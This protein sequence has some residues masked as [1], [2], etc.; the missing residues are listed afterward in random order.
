MPSQEDAPKDE[1]PKSKAPKAPKAPKAKASKSTAPRSK[2]SPKAPK[3]AAPQ[4]PLD[5]LAKVC[6]NVRPAD[7]AE[8]VL[9]VAPRFVAEPS[10][11]AEAAEVMRVAAEHGLAVV[12]R[13]GE[14]RLEWGMPPSRCDLLVDT[15]RLD[16]VIEHA[17]G[18]LVVKAEAGLSMERLAEVLA[19]RGQRL[20]LDTPLP[21]ST[22]GGTIAT[23]A[24]GPLRLLYGSPRDL[25]IGLTFIRADGQIARSG[26]K[27]VKNV[28]GYDLG[29][30]FSGSY[31]TLGLIVEAVFRLHPIPTA[32]AYVTAPVADPSQA[33]EA[34]QA[35]LHSPVA[36][37]ALE[38]DASASG[39]AIG[40]L[41]EGVPDGVAARSTQ[42]A[43]LLGAQAHI[44]QEPP[45]WWGAYPDGTTLVEVTAPPTALRPLLAEAQQQSPV[46]W[47][48]T[49]KGFVGMEGPADE[50][51][52][53]LARLRSALARHNGGAVIRYAP[54][55]VRA[56]ADVWG[57]VAALTLMR[58]VK[59]QFDPDHRLSP[60]RFVGGI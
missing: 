19:E 14:T 4:G 52:D 43:D 51:A 28:A 30:L 44:S 22:I 31:G 39:T 60:G 48:A 5:A 46:R 3:D 27:V 16:K 12:P 2:A 26:G 20:A 54:E 24:A 9:G 25:V 53:T 47:S 37:S 32:H 50:V 36:P 23:G 17:A 42:V 49:G 6:A 1:A 21:G 10:S 8:G 41:I 38:C 56:Q 33:H 45:S 57:P 55:D 7:A 13:G 34:V 15:V 29:R 35:V 11:V 59:D 18:D 58:R 40:V